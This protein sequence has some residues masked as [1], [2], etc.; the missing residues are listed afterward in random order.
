MEF[1]HYDTF[2]L[3]G[4]MEEIILPSRF[5]HGNKLTSYLTT[6]INVMTNHRMFFVF[7]VGFVTSIIILSENN[8]STNKTCIQTSEQFFVLQSWLIHI[9]FNV[10]STTE[11]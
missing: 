3:Q 11:I 7:R 6:D 9:I 1:Y 2:R 5:N 8:V 4:C 10:I